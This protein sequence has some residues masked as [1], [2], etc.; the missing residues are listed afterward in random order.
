[1]G[2]FSSPINPIIGQSSERLRKT[3]IRSF[4]QLS[5]NK[6]GRGFLLLVAA[7]LL[8]SG[9]LAQWFQKDRVIMTI[10]E[11]KI[12]WTDALKRK[13]LLF[14]DQKKT[15]WP[16]QMIKHPSFL[17]WMLQL[18]LAKEREQFFSTKRA[19]LMFKNTALF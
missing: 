13:F 10:G 1:L 12:Y 3:V 16:E 8:V 6:F 9:N 5:Q 18:F 14:V 7:S 19:C 2:C 4:R 17:P 11:K 15:Q